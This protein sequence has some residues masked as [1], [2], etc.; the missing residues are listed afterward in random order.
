MQA[1]GG[2]VEAAHEQVPQPDSR[3]RR[4]Q[5]V[6]SEPRQVPQP[7]AA[8]GRAGDLE[9]A[10]EGLLQGD[11][12]LGSEGLLLGQRLPG[13]AQ[14]LDRNPE[15]GRA[16]AL[17]EEPLQMSPGVEQA[18]RRLGLGKRA[19]EEGPQALL[20]FLGQGGVV[21]GHEREQLQAALEA[22]AEG[23]L[24]S[25]DRILCQVQGAETRIRTDG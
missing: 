12:A 20:H 15:Q 2:W 17:Q 23:V 4:T 21:T 3:R 8:L 22:H 9:G 11:Q 5:G 6:V 10:G 13:I 16:V 14:P 1:I 7:C 24:V 19:L 25:H 18:D